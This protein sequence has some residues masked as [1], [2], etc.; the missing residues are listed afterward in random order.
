M[1]RARSATTIGLAL[2]TSCGDDPARPEERASRPAF[3]ISSPA[4]GDM[5]QSGTLET[6]SITVTGE[7]CDPSDNIAGLTLNGIAIP[8]TGTSRCQSFSVAQPSRWGLTTITGEARNTRGRTTRLAR[9]FLR[10]P[11]Y[12]PPAD[13]ADASARV[14][15]GISA[16]LTQAV[17]DPGVA[18]IAWQYTNRVSWDAFFPVGEVWV[19]VPSEPISYDCFGVTVPS[20]TTGYFMRRHLSP[21]RRVL[22]PDLSVHAS[23]RQGNH[24]DFSVRMQLD[25][26]VQINAT[27]NLGCL[28]YES[29][30]TVNGSV[31]A[32]ALEFGWSVGL[33]I[34]QLGV[35]RDTVRSFM[36]SLTTNYG[37]QYFAFS[38]PPAYPTDLWRSIAY[39]RFELGVD[40]VVDHTLMQQVVPAL[41]QLLSGLAPLS[42]PAAPSPG[43]LPAIVARPDS[44]GSGTGLISVTSAVQLHPT[45][46]RSGPT[47]ARGALRRDGET[48][49]AATLQGSAFGTGIKDDVVNQFFWSAW[50]GGAFDGTGTLA[51]QCQNAVP[52]VTVSS[53]AL[54]PPV[55][56]A[57]AGDSVT[58]GFGDL[59]LTGTV[60]AVSVELYASNRMAGTLGIGAPDALTITFDAADETHMEITAISDSTALDAMPAALAPYVACLTRTMGRLAIES[61]PLPVFLQPSVPGLSTTPWRPGNPTVAR[62]GNYTVLRGSAP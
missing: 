58:I 16:H 8:V 61:V 33:G 22:A 18:A 6:S 52:G 49:N 34:Q 23:A 28:G 7:V 48:P 3:T 1:R 60:G 25:V 56:M 10:G 4:R 36:T 27:L 46:V 2:L 15:R 50:R 43:L 13:N 14:P 62:S 5:L 41:E 32:D 26:P 39:D 30:G 53:Y 51:P 21:A 44:L 19:H 38:F 40:M 17:L 35:G 24:L 57:G 37:T 42:P 31:G 54:L 55:L 11:T 9:S 29:T 20:R 45:A 59:R 47:A 12:F